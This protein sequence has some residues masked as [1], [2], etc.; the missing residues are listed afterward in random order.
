[1]PRP[2]KT[3]TLCVMAAIDVYT[4]MLLGDM[5]TFSGSDGI[6]AREHDIINFGGPKFSV[7]IVHRREYTAGL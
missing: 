4:G 7:A 1:M 3:S 6:S 2:S 5:V